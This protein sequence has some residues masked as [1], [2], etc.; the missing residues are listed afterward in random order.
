M[1]MIWTGQEV[2]PRKRY[3]HKYVVSW[4]QV[5]EAISNSTI[6]PEEAMRLLSAERNSFKR[7]YVMK[8]LINVY[9]NAQR[10][11]LYA[12]CEMPMPKKYA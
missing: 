10:R 3:Q 8:K 11:V 9:L 12:K 7:E 4:A 2:S 6:T 5:R 1:K